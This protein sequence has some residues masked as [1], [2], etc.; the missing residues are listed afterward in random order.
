MQ[1]RIFTVPATDDGTAMDEMNRFLRSHKVLEVDR[2]LVSTRTGAQ[3]HFCVK[4]LAN[5]PV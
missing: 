2:Q 1:F 4:Y 5:A 3:W